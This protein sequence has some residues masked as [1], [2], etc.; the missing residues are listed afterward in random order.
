MLL[1]ARLARPCTTVSIWF[2]AE[3]E[4][5]RVEWAEQSCTK[6]IS[7][8]RD[9]LEEYNDSLA[10]LADVEKQLQIPE[11]PQVIAVHEGLWE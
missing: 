2:D 9:V 7:T 5:E 4:D 10:V 8:E 11:V 1:Q 6:G 3:G